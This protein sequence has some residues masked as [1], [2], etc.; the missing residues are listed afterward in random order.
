MNCF[1]LLSQMLTFDHAWTIWVSQKFCNILAR[2]NSAGF[3][4]IVK[5]TNNF[6]LWDAKVPWYYPCATHWIYFN[7]LKHRTRI[8]YLTYLTL[9]DYQGSCN[10]IKISWTIWL[11][12]S[13]Q[14]CLHNL[15]NKSLCCFCDVMIQFKLIKCK[16]PNQMM[17]HVYLRGFQMH[18]VWAHQPQWVLSMIWTALVTWYT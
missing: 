12:Y 10:Q 6:E 13:D 18:N 3:V 11:L 4:E 9:P 2:H 14:L 15:H 5:V 7:G 8:H 17:L 16:F 1:W